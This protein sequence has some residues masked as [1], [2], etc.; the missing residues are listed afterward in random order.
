MAHDDPDDRGR[1]RAAPHTPETAG[2]ER[3]RSWACLDADSVPH[4]GPNF[5]DTVV[6]EG[7]P[8]A[9]GQLVAVARVAPHERAAGADRRRASDALGCVQRIPGRQPRALEIEGRIRGEPPRE[10]DV[11]LGSEI[12]GIAFYKALIRL[13]RT[14]DAPGA[15]VR[16]GACGLD[17]GVGVDL[18]SRPRRAHDSIH[19]ERGRDAV[20]RPQAEPGPAGTGVADP[21]RHGKESA[22]EVVGAG[23]QDGCPAGVVASVSSEWLIVAFALGEVVPGLVA[24][25]VDP[26]KF[27][28]HRAQ[29]VAGDRVEEPGRQIAV[30]PTDAAVGLGPLGRGTTPL[31]VERGIE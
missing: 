11:D 27:E 6:L 23:C 1:R 14:V 15:G 12:V 17:A 25:T 28:E 7:Q 31:V 16:R 4:A 29:L 8:H 19:T 13:D 10:P 24:R 30:D 5:S 26:P 21:P 2:L 22:V 3:L 20:R 9:R 18:L